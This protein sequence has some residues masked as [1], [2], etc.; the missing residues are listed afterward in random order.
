MKRK[1]LIRLCTTLMVLMLVFQTAFSTE[2]RLNSMGGTGFYTRDNTNI[3]TFQGTINQYSNQV[4]S[5]LR[6]KNS[7]ENYS[8]GGLLPVNEKS[9][10][11]IFLNRPVGNFAP[12]GLL[13]NIQISQTTDIFYGHTFDNWNLG[14]QLSVGMDSYNSEEDTLKVKESLGYYA[15][16]VGVSNENT[17]LS[18]SFLLPS[19]NREVGHEKDKW[20]GFGYTFNARH[21]L[22]Q[23]DKIEFV[24]VARFYNLPSNADYS[25]DYD[26]IDMNVKYTNF[27]FGAG[28][29]MNYHIDDNSLIVL[30]VEGFGYEKTKA[31]FENELTNETRKITLPGIYLGVESKIKPWLTGRF[32]ASQIY[33]K[34]S[35]KIKYSNSD[36]I[37]N[38][39]NEKKFK[40]S[41]GV[42][43][44]LNK[45]IMDLS[46]NEGL[47]FEGPNFISG[48]NESLSNQ[49]SF[50]YIF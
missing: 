2:T 32:G 38:S 41:F 48:A 14:V 20:S 1:Y 18:L 44:K 24:P 4:W 28:I 43:I 12:L 42:G 26:S 16:G 34:I 45:F 6:V 49:L 22:K 50:S 13:K 33:Q 11:G 21:F 10:L 46:I 17:D 3:F 40:L 37:E 31:K 30:G 29:G 5:E 23:S 25:I 19:A 35:E 15:L 47:F 7:N 39:Y 27:R 8:I 9:T 36:T